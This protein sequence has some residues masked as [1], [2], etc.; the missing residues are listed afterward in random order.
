MKKYFSILIVDDEQDL[1][2]S[3]KELFIREGYQVD[4]AENGIEALELF[5]AKTYDLVLS[6]I[7]MQG[8]SGN[9]VLEQ[10]KSLKPEVPF[11][12]ITGYSSI[13]GAIDA[14][15]LGAD[16]YFVKPFEIDKV[17]AVIKRIYDN[18]I[19]TKKNNIR[20]EEMHNKDFPT[21]IGKSD[22]IKKVLEDIRIVADS[23]VSVMIS[24]ESGTGKELVARA[25]HELSSRQNKDIIPVNCAAIPQDLLES[26]F[27][28]H[29]KGSFSGAFKRKLGLL[30]IAH[31]GTLF[32]DEIGEMSLSLQPKLLRA[33]ETKQIRRIGGSEEIKVNTRIISSTNVDL[34]KEVEAGNFRKDLYYRLAP[35]TIEIPPLRER[36]DDI[37]LITNYLISRKKIPNISFSQDIIDAFI[38]YDW[39]GNIRELENVIER[40]ILITKGMVPEFSNLP[41]EIKKVCYEKPKSSIKSEDEMVSLEELEKIHIQKVFNSCNCDKVRTADILGIGLKTL[42]RKIE[43]YQINSI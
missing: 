28:G 15:K 25:I 26:E 22:L 5:Q 43:K 16:D 21:I 29:E 12:L 37:Q 24:G 41:S 2:E 32:L 18:N 33:V 4:L 40:I 36:K 42:Y 9:E 6:D 23:D 19:L 39:P 8:M 10:C 7:I 30:E 17:R 35:Y 27:F 38:L 34:K 31:H 1:R 14:I 11:I 13:Q 20:I 3:L